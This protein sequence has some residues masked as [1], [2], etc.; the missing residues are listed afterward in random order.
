MNSRILVDS[1]NRTPRITVL[2]SLI[3]KLKNTFLNKHIFTKTRIFVKTKN[4]RI[5]EILDNHIKNSFR[6]LN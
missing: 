6:E 3:S 2:K 5:F 1:N 4:W